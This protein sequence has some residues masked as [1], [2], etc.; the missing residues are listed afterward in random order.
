ME[1]KELKE[2]VINID[3]NIE[4]LKKDVQIRNFNIKAKPLHFAV[5]GLVAAFV[6]SSV[7]TYT[8]QNFEEHLPGALLSAGIALG[9]FYVIFM[10]ICEV[11]E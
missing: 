2:K 5:T 3:K 1:E 8:L 6:F 11:E 7:V 10:A 9:I 4:E